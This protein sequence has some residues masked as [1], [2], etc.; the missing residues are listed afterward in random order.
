MPNAAIDVGSNSLLLTVMGDGGV[1]LHDEARVVGLGKGLGDRGLFQPDRMKA[2]E[3][4]LADYVATAAGLGVPANRIR[5]VATSAARRAM[6]AETWLARVKRNLDVEVRVISGEEEADLTWAGARGGL[7]LP[8]GAWLVVDLGGGSTELVLGDAG[9]AQ[10]RASLQLG[11]VRLTED[12]LGADKIDPTALA[13]ARSW[14][15]VELAR[16][17][18]DAAPAAVVGVAGTVTTLVTV[19]RGHDRYRRDDV[20]GQVLTRA[21]LQRA[22]DRLAPATPEERRRM[23]PASPERANYLVAG[24]TIL[25]RT[26]AAA[27]KDALIASDGGLR[28]GLLAR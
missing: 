18:F 2:A 7:D 21:D 17:P 20:H 19:A 11:S 10:R 25:D 28:F 15:D 23:V 16:F 5:A 3:E 26:L 13:R 6:N 14:V 4:V 24:A 27:R 1:V 9:G 12:L 22:I 8:A